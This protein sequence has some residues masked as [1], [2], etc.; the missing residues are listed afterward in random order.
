MS[1]GEKAMRPRKT[2]G[3]FF[4]AV[5]PRRYANAQP[6]TTLNDRGIVDKTDYIK[7]LEDRLQYR[8]STFHLQ[9]VN[10]SLSSR[11]IRIQPLRNG[12]LVHI[13]EV[14]V[15]RHAETIYVSNPHELGGGNVPLTR[16]DYET[17]HG[18]PFRCS[19]GFLSS[20]F[21]RR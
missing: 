7:L 11:S 20:F 1:Q 18:D 12:P 15:S 4:D 9:E 14:E 21:W 8:E 10:E 5:L 19:P 17:P 2:Q 6:L 16:G 3:P 13:E